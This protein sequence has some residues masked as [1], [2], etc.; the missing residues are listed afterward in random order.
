MIVVF[1]RSQF[2]RYRHLGSNTQCSLLESLMHWNLSTLITRNIISCWG[3]I[4]WLT[5]KVFS[6]GH[7]GTEPCTDCLSKFRCFS[8]AVFYCHNRS[9]QSTSYT[10]ST[11]QHYPCSFIF[12][13]C[14]YTMYGN[15][16]AQLHIFAHN[17]IFIIITV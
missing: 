16:T 13:S 9:V 5:T 7:D 17:I 4:V 11:S 15:N 14:I 10:Y 1:V 8:F 12:M 2:K 3:S 6:D